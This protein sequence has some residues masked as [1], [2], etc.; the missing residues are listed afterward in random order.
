MKSLSKLNWFGFFIV[1]LI[2]TVGAVA[3]KN[4]NSFTEGMVI[5]AVFGLPCSVFVLFA[6]RKK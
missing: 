2:C 1:L 4:I 5:I 3:N 6:G